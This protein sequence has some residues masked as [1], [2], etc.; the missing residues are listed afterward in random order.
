[1]VTHLPR[2]FAEQHYNLWPTVGDSFR[3]AG[4]ISLGV[5]QRVAGDG[6][7]RH[8]AS[9]RSGECSR[10]DGRLRSERAA[11]AEANGGRWGVSKPVHQF[12]PDVALQRRTTAGTSVNGRVCAS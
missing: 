11:R 2:Q 5:V 7:S 1:V 8:R 4:S 3:W 12:L 6:R 9:D 10:N